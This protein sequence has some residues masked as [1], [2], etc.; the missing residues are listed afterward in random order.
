MLDVAVVARKFRPLLFGIISINTTSPTRD[1]IDPFAELANV[2]KCKFQKWK[3]K[4]SSQY[5]IYFQLR[6]IYNILETAITSVPE[7]DK[8]EK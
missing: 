4:E 2:R 8:N 3:K 5:Y 1:Y 6:R 7:H